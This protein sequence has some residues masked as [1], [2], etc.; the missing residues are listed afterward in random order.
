MDISQN[1]E[2]CSMSYETFM[3]IPVTLSLPVIEQN[4]QVF[5]HKL[6]FHCWECFKRSTKCEKQY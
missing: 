3:L 2:V 6:T 1:R 4:V 5:I